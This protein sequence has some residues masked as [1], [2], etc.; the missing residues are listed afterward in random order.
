[1]D[2]KRT[3][4]ALSMGKGAH[5]G[6]IDILSR[7]RRY[8]KEPKL[9][10]RQIVFLGDYRSGLSTNQSRRKGKRERG[11]HCITVTDSIIRQNMSL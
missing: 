10:S 5:L 7:R 8:G 3:L 4:Y 11:L 2:A 6:N 9:S 1:M